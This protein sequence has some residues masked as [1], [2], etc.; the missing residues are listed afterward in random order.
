MNIDMT[1]VP[2]EYKRAAAKDSQGTITDVSYPVRNYINSSRQLVT[3]Q[4]I[5]SLKKRK[6]NCGGRHH[7][8]EIAISICLLDMRKND[9]G[10]NIMF[11]STPL[12]E[13]AMNG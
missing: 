1:Q 13:I 8:K 4:N 5:C 12:V 6:G 2:A 3:D 11:I 10:T 7:H 9:T